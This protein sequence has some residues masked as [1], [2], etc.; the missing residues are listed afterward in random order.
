MLRQG[1]NRGIGFAVPSNTERAV[2][3]A[4]GGSYTIVTRR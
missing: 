3:A 4:L 1:A 2:A